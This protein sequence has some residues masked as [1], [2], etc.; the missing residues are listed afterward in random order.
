MLWSAIIV[1][2]RQIQGPADAPVGRRRTR[3]PETEQSLECGHRHPPAVV[4]KNE[5]VQVNL[6]LWAT[7]A[8]VGANEPLLKV[9]DRPVHQW[10]RRLGPLAQVDSQGLGT[11][12]CW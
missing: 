11:R 2:L 7:D 10:H 4:S 5:F 3:G 6:K 1:Q 9:A 12:N 8:V